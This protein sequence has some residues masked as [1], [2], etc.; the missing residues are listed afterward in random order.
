MLSDIKTDNFSSCIESN[1]KE[2]VSIL[3]FL[4]HFCSFSYNGVYCVKTGTF[5][6]ANKRREY[7]VQ[8]W[9]WDT[10]HTK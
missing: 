7:G 1:T 9:V 6:T 10:K 3:V 8:M 2:A 5:L 4:S